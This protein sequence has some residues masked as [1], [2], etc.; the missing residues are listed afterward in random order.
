LKPLNFKINSLLAVLILVAIL[1]TSGCIYLVVGGLGAVGGYVVSPDT[2]EG[3]IEYE[4]VVVWDASIEIL[5]IM[6]LVVEENE[7]DGT[8][9]ANVGGSRITATITPLEK[10]AVRLTVR[11]R[12]AFMPKVSLAQ[13]VFVKINNYLGQ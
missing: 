1:S 9:V 12:K 11:A 2:F 13:D 4:E 7:E 6:G 8:I 5:S 3:I 10:A